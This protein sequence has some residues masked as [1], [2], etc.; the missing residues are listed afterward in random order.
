M[1]ENFGVDNPLE[2]V[3]EEIREIEEKETKH[4]KEEQERSKFN[5]WIAITISIYA[6][7]TAIAGLKEGQVTTET[8][9]EMDNAVLYQ[10][11]A[12]DQWSFYQAKSIKG[13]I[14]KTSGVNVT[15]PNTKK[16]Y[17]A[18]VKRYDSEK[19][20]VQKTAEELEK[21]RDAK[22]NETNHFIHQHHSAGLA[23]VFFQIAIVLASV[24]SLLRK[25]VLWFVSMFVS[26][27]GIYYVIPLL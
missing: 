23:L 20:E 24:S 6:V 27:V 25:K 22:M 14:Y 19:A 16:E 11:Q 26:V 3:E 4:H 5:N 17:D 15:D 9:L 2:K 21:K 1:T 13:E 18:N 8:L 7:L 10:A 12:S